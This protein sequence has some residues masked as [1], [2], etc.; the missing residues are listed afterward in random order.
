MEMTLRSTNCL[1]PSKPSIFLHIYT[2]SLVNRRLA[3]VIGTHSAKKPIMI[4][5]CTRNSAV[6][7]AKELA[8]LWST[9]NHPARLWKG[10]SKPMPVCNTDLKSES[11][12][13]HLYRC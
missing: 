4:F 11:D 5:C 2:G 10:P 9:S 3:D 8:R 1:T 13:T 12:Y 7:T 6:T